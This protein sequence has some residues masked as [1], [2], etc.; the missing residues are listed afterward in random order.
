MFASQPLPKGNRM[1]IIS[2][3]GAV[4]VLATDEGATYGLTTPS[5]SP[6]TASKLN[7]IFPGLGMT[8]V[9]IGP[10]MVVA[11]DSSTFYQEILATVL[12]D[13]HVDCLFNVLWAGPM[14]GSSEIYLKA[15][16]ALGRN[17]PK[18]IATWVYG[19]RL[20]LISGLSQR[21]EDL[22]FPVFSDL[23]MAVKALGM[24]W[25]YSRRKKERK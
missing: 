22:G 14:E 7:A 18:P 8:I 5:L 13:D 16:E 3:T 12:E 9:D 24:A 1:A 19:P 6:Y 20:P 2:Y 4:G 25:Q 11:R 10:L 23:E 15:Y 17:P 21:L